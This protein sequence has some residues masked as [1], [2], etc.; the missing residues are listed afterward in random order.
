MR[1]LWSVILSIMSVKRRIQMI[2]VVME[3]FMMLQ[4]CKFLMKMIHK[5]ILLRNRCSI[6]KYLK[7]LMAKMVLPSLLLNLDIK[8]KRLKLSLFFKKNNNLRKLLLKEIKICNISKKLPILNPSENLFLDGVVI[9]CC[10]IKLWYTKKRIW[11]LIKF[12]GK[13]TQED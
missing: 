11:T 6:L 4:I 8:V 2:L 5:L 10:L 9:W 1:S 13:W 3:N 12:L 7:I